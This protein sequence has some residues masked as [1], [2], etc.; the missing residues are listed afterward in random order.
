MKALCSELGDRMPALHAST[1]WYMTPDGLLFYWR[2]RIEYIFNTYLIWLGSSGTQGEKTINTKKYFNL[3]RFYPGCWVN[4]SSE[5]RSTLQHL[6]P[7]LGGELCIIHS[8]RSTEKK[9]LLKPKQT[10]RFDLYFLPG[11]IFCSLQ[12]FLKPLSFF[13]SVSMYF[14]YYFHIL[15]LFCNFKM[16]KWRKATWHTCIDRNR[17]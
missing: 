1:G 6:V 2:T 8:P 13:L 4:A 9:R 7:L 5:R 10:P 17:I 15:F 14:L 11:L 3:S 16:M 12:V